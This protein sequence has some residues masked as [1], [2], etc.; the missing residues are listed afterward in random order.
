MAG[1]N[2]TR[3]HTAGKIAIKFHFLLSLALCSLCKMLTMFL[4]QKES[5]NGKSKWIGRGYGLFSLPN[6]GVL[7]NG[8]LFKYQFYS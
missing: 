4:K 2:W 3:K 5:R 1:D 8:I 7:Y 6:R